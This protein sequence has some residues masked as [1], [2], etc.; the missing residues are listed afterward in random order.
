MRVRTRRLEKLRSCEPRSAKIVEVFDGNDAIQAGLTMPAPAPGTT[1]YLGRQLVERLGPYST[2]LSVA[3][4]ELKTAS[5][6]I[7]QSSVPIPS[8]VATN[9][10]T[11]DV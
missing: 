7:R 3:L 10:R 4:H 8:A 1:C 9:A 6:N 2:Y 5:A 11:L